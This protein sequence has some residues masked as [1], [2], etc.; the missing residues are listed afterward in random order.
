MGP[1]KGYLQGLCDTVNAMYI[2]TYV[3][4]RIIS[5]H[6]EHLGLHSAV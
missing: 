6:V 2:Y 4:I 5:G 1:C 3:A